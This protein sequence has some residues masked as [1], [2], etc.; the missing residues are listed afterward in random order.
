MVEQEDN[1]AAA[2]HAHGGAG[3][4]QGQPRAVPDL[5]PNQAGPQ[6]AT[7]TESKEVA[8][9]QMVALQVSKE[10]TN[11]QHHGVVAQQMG[12]LQTTL[13]RILT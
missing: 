7:I 2:C 6:G 4:G 10:L 8:S 9:Q 1:L 12:I 11:Y 3:E 5:N 13:S